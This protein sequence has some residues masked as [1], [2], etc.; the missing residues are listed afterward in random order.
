MQRPHDGNDARGEEAWLLASP[1]F[2]R[3][4]HHFSSWL[5]ES[6]R[7]RESHIPQPSSPR[8]TGLR[9]STFASPIEW[10]TE[11][12]SRR[13]PDRPSR[14][15][16]ST[17]DDIATPRHDEME[18]DPE[19]EQPFSFDRIADVYRRLDRIQDNV[20][21]LH[22]TLQDH[23]RRTDTRFSAIMLSLQELVNERT[24]NSPR[25]VH[26]TS[27][28]PREKGK[29]SRANYLRRSDASASMSDSLSVSGVPIPCPTLHQNRR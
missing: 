24:S 7:F 29:D 13:I 8:I 26:D 14:R 1:P 15:E 11:E 10:L 23:Q 4:P 5:L 18:V 12:Q 9:E 6:P 2:E 25:R 17:A 3:A 21:Q 16:G 27:R 22:H 20:H 19:V 28:P